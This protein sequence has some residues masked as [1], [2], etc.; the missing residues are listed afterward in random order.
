MSVLKIVSKLPTLTTC[1]PPLKMPREYRKRGKKHK[2]QVEEKED[3]PPPQEIAQQPSWIVSASAMD[4]TRDSE[5]PFGELEAD[6]KAYFRTVD[7]QLR[8]WQENQD[9]GG[10]EDDGQSNESKQINLTFHILV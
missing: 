6:I 10:E 9:D 1:E 3:D 2:K 8:D 5:T 4:T 7:L